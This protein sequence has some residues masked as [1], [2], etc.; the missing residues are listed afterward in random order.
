MGRKW[1][2]PKLQVLVR[3]RPE[4]KVLAGCKYDSRTGETSNASGCRVSTC[5]NCEFSQIS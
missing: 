5:G 3:Q 1:E 4:E 2:K